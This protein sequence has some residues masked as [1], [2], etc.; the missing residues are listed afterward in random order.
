MRNKSPF[1]EPLTKLMKVR[2]VQE[3]NRHKNKTHPCIFLWCVFGLFNGGSMIRTGPAQFTH[4]PKRRSSEEC[5]VTGQCLVNRLGHWNDG[6]TKAEAGTTE[7]PSLLTICGQC[8]APR[9]RW[10]KGKNEAC[11]CKIELFSTN[12]TFAQCVDNIP[13][14]SGKKI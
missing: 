3:K 4:H 2:V 7:E 8:P 12:A 10:R 6:A 13:H 11:L 1:F 5:K 14:V 9:I